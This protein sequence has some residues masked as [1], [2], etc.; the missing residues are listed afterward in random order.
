MG[1]Y[2]HQNYSYN[3]TPPPPSDT[4]VALNVSPHYL[5]FLGFNIAVEISTAS[6]FRKPPKNM[7]LSSIVVMAYFDTGASVSSIDINLAK[8]LKLDSTGQSQSRTAS[9]SEIVPNFVIDI[10]FPNTTLSPFHNLRISSCKLGFDLAKS[11]K[12]Q[13][14][15]Q[16]FGLLIG[17]DIMSQWNIVWNGP[18]STVIIND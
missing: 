5:Y 6:C 12:N 18:T 3:I 14:D 2:T 4:Q 10:S 9:G 13:N 15:P 8:Y 17:R 11:I 16:N 7:P 1:I